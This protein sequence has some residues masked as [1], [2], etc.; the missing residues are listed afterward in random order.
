MGD[1]PNQEILI[2]GEMSVL[3]DACVCF[4]GVTTDYDKFAAPSSTPTPCVEE[5]DGVADI[6]LGEEELGDRSGAK[7]VGEK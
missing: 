3:T 6:V 2:N 5:G 1:I 7:R 4:T